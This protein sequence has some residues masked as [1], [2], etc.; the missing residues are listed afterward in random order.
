MKLKG[1]FFFLPLI[2]DSLLKVCKYMQ[3][4]DILIEESDI[5]GSNT[6]R[7]WREKII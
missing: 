2:L 4:I 6:G 7:C 1:F 3:S 5:F